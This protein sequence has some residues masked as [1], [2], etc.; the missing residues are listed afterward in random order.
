MDFH[1]EELIQLSEEE[2]L[3]LWIEY[4]K[5]GNAEIREKLILKYAPLVKYVA[6]KVAIGMPKKIEFDDLVGY[7]I[8]GLLDAIDKFDPARK[9]KFKTYAITRIRGAIFDELRS[10]DW[11]PRTV[12]QKAKQ[13]DKVLTELEDQLE[14]TPTDEEIAQA[15]EISEKELQKLYL[16]LSSTT[17]HSFNDPIYSDDSDGEQATVVNTIEASSGYNPEMISEKE[18]I[19]KMIGQIIEE[20][21]DKEKQVLILYYYEDLTLKE[22]G[23]VLQ[24]TE[25]RVSQLHT[26]AIFKLKAKLKKLQKKLGKPVK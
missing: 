6:G 12:R 2:E 5:T 21:S 15:L 11:V 25:S 14:R 4:K 16:S 24:V 18:E 1:N 19:K 20:L 13:L 22:I 8:F 26:K 23:Q 17:I 7:G 3:K 9:T 10:I